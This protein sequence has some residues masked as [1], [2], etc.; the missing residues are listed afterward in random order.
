MILEDDSVKKARR[1]VE[2]KM[3]VHVQQISATQDQVRGRDSY[4]VVACMCSSAALSA[5]WQTRLQLT[6]Q[7]C[8]KYEKK[9]MMMMMMIAL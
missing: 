1:D 7:L 2:K 5:E 6:G 9:Q 4:L 3:T 8:W